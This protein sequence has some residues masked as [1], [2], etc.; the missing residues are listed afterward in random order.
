MIKLLGRIVL[1]LALW[2]GVTHASYATMATS[3]AS[4]DN[5]QSAIQCTGVNII[6]DMERDQPDLAEKMRQEAADTPFGEGLIWK[7]EKPGTKPS[8]LFGTIHLADPRLLALKPAA[9]KAFDESTTLALEITEILDPKKLAGIAFTALQY[10]S[11]T[12]GSTLA[13]KLTEED[14]TLIGEVARKKLGLPWSLAS[15]M[16]PWALMGALGLP[17]CEMERKKAQLPV[18]DAYLGQLA[19]SQNKQIVPLETMIGQLQAMDS[20]PEDVSIK[21]LVQSVSLGKRMDDLFETMIQLYLEEKT[22]LVW[23]MMRRVGVDGFVEKQDS[24]EYA[25]F[26]REIVDRRNVTMVEE[27]EKYL[28]QGGVFVAVGA[29]HLPGEAGMLNILAQKGYSISRIT[30]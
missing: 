24:A 10:T 26:Q 14:A 7:I 6:P 27:A 5:E 9:R 3:G 18:V 15:K 1:A 22:A 2:V 29:L 25:A 8:Y 11:Y 30:D 28:E 16:K 13:D 19:Q 20:L 12:D 23:S 4:A 21:G 17:A